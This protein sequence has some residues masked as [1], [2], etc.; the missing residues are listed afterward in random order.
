MIWAC[1]TIGLLVGAA[2][3]P[4][5]R[6]AAETPDACD[7]VPGQANGLD[8]AQQRNAKIIAGVAFAR[9]LG[10]TGAT[11]GIAAALA[12]S[13]LLNYAN[14]GTSTLVGRHEGR[15]LT[16]A[17]RAVV[18]QSLKYPHDRVGNNLDSVGLF[19]QRPM[20]GWGPP[21]LLI[22]PVRAAGLFFDRMEQV[23]GWQALPPWQVAQDVQGSPSSDGGL[24][25]RTHEQAVK[26]VAE[27]TK[28]AAGAVTAATAADWCHRVTLS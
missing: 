5:A 11:I 4:A 13:T 9:G 18:R 6:Q 17:E 21:R 20:M 24:Y 8:P 28:P 14:D 23:S 10:A 27:L 22:D 1:A 26:I 16:H 2:I 7:L 19:Q 12:E 15:P 3:P 25:R